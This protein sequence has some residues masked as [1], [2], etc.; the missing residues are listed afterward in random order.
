M[1]SSN[2][3]DQRIPRVR[4]NAPL[5]RPERMI[6]MTRILLAS[7][8][9]AALGSGVMAGFFY[10][11]SNVVMGALGR[12]PAPAGITVMQQVNIVVINPLFMLLF[13]GTALLSLLLVAAPLIGYGGPGSGFAAAG[14]VAYLVTI[15]VVTMVF[16]VPMNN[17]LATVDADSA[18]GATL[19][20]DY[21][22][23]WTLWNHV[24]GIGGF[25]SMALFVLA[26]A[27]RG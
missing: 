19:W 3:D 20:A 6:A 14:A 5:R 10:G 11:F 24:R 22:T 2:S 18:A 13:M 25:V 9:L 27:W 17:A 26:L 23:R 21:L 8:V 15:M 12:L 16:N 1:F 7:T 4:R